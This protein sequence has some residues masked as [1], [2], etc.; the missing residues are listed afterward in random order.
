MIEYEYR[1]G[2]VFKG[3]IFC[4]HVGCRVEYSEGFIAKNIPSH[5]FKALKEFRKNLEE[6]RYISGGIV[7]RIV[8]EVEE[9][10][11]LKCPACLQVFIDFSGCTQLTCCRCHHQFCAV[12][13]RPYVRSRVIHEE[14]CS[15]STRDYKRRHIIYS[16]MQ[17]N[18]KSITICR[19]Y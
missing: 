6:Q 17:G 16:S 7:E 10:L 9:S 12:C 15:N 13:Q 14:Y 11:N 2:Y 19:R 18:S 5:T 3:K 1:R 8:H 4:P